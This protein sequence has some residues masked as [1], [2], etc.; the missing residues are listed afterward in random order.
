MTA[1]Q[2]PPR[3]HASPLAERLILSL[4]PVEWRDFGDAGISR[5]RTS[6]GGRRRSRCRTTDLSLRTTSRL[7]RRS[8]AIVPGFEPASNTS[9]RRLLSPAARWRGHYG[10]HA[11]RDRMQ[12]TEF[13]APTLNEHAMSDTESIES[14][15]ETPPEDKR[16]RSMWRQLFGDASVQV[17]FADS[18]LNARVY[19]LDGES[20]YKVQHKKVGGTN[21]VE[22]PEDLASQ[23]LAFPKK[24]RRGE[25]HGRAYLTETDVRII[26]AWALNFTSHKLAPPWTAK[27]KEMN[28][29][30]GTLRDIVA[31]RTW[32][33]LH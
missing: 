3:L 21:P 29:S 23:R 32:S 12:T 11:H 25:K 31:R 19:T 33:H 18:E 22:E 7:R 20:G 8:S 9:D 13:I 6:C 26:R 30:E 10:V 2:T 17:Y 28:V 15:S 14:E 1:P 5:P 27:A 24:A 16:F 4:T